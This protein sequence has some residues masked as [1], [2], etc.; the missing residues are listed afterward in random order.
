MKKRFISLLLCVACAAS[1]AACGS[2]DGNGNG[3]SSVVQVEKKPDPK[4]VTYMSVD[5]PAREMA[6][7]NLANS[8]LITDMTYETIQDNVMFSPLSLNFALGMVLEGTDGDS[9]SR[10]A[11]EQYLNQENYSAFVKSYMDYAK[12]IESMPVPEGST[13]Q[14]HYDIANAVW[15]NQEYPLKEKYKTSVSENYG[16][17]VQNLDF[18]KPEEVADTV[19]AWVAKQ[20]RNMIP[21]ILSS[22]MITEDSRAVLTNAIYFESPWQKEWDPST[23]DRTFTNADGSTCGPEFMD[24]KACCGYFANEK[25]TAFAKKY[26]SGLEFIGILP[27][28]TG[29]FTLADLEIEELLTKRESV[30]TYAAMPTLDFETNIALTEMLKSLGMD[31]LFSDNADITEMCDVELKISDVLQKTKLELDAK[32]TKAAAVTAIT[33]E[34]CEAC[35]EPPREEV[36]ILDRPF[37]FL[38]Y[39]AENQVPVFMGKVTNLNE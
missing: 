7:S 24:T 37:A 32:G 9:P 17:E 11:L 13:M 16:A 19:N 3:G 21:S 27:K 1:L 18:S 15:V 14:N 33:M 10:A 34:A 20:T 23:Y 35:E 28:E 39:D 8:V 2:G 4:P 12:T 36:V 29:D 30:L 26:A 6:A 38:I 31:I 5:L 22:D 25:A